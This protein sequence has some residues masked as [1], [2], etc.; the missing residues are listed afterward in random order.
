MLRLIIYKKNACVYLVEGTKT[1]IAKFDKN[2]SAFEIICEL[3]YKIT[4]LFWNTYRGFFHKG[5][6]Y[7]VETLTDTAY[8]FKELIEGEN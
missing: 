7:K 1:P 3:N 6:F 4:R 5:K 8:K 2:S